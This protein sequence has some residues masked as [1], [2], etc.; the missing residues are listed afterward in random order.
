M[1]WV[2]AHRMGCNRGDKDIH[3]IVQN[4]NKYNPL[5]SNRIKLI[6]QYRH[7]MKKHTNLQHSW[8]PEWANFHVLASPKFQYIFRN[9]I[10]PFSVTVGNFASQYEKMWHYHIIFIAVFIGQCTCSEFIWSVETRTALDTVHYQTD[11]LNI[12]HDTEQIPQ[13]L[14]LSGRISGNQYITQH[15]SYVYSDS[16]NRSQEWI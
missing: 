7:F 16:Y 15:H 14:G 1:P 13:C 11:G 4:L 6:M 9:I 2:L 3:F 10:I 12:S 8:A 5:H